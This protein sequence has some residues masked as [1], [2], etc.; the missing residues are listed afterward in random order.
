MR[1]RR[2]GILT[3]ALCVLGYATVLSETPLPPGIDVTTL[4]ET[5]PYS[6]QA[7]RCAAFARYSLYLLTGRR[8][9]TGGSAWSWA[10]EAL[11][12]GAQVALRNVKPGD[13]LFFRDRQHHI[14]HVAVVLSNP[15]S[16]IATL[17]FLDERG[18]HAWQNGQDYLGLHPVFGADPEKLPTVS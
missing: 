7:H 13:L 5:N 12:R 8:L 1:L 6:G 18:T 16:H 11:R 17:S 2:S 14:R 3:A 10:R 15:S 9:S 4:T